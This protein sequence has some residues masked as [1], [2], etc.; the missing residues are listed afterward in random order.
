MENIKGGNYFSVDHPL[1][2]SVVMKT[3][4]LPGKVVNG[5]QNGRWTKEE[6]QKFLEGLSKYGREWKKVAAEIKTRSSA[7]VTIL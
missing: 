7:Q 2:Q 3:T 1:V 6:H 4:G 5:S